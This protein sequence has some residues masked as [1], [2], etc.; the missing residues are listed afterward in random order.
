MDVYS[1]NLTKSINKTSIFEFLTFSWVVMSYLIVS[2]QPL[3]S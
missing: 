1:E 2:V 3:I